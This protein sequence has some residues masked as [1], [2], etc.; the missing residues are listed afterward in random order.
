[1]APKAWQESEK[2]RHKWLCLR[3]KHN[4]G[5]GAGRRQKKALRV[6]WRFSLLEHGGQRRS[7]R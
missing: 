4:L 3:N 2:Q 7:C 6:Q 5:V 1:M